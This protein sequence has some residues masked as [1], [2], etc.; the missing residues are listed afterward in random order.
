MKGQGVIGGLVILVVAS[1]FV[2]TIISGLLRPAY[3]LETITNESVA[4]TAG[5]GTLAYYPIS[6][7][8]SVSNTTDMFTAVTDYNITTASTGV[9]AFGGAI[10]TTPV[11]VTYKYEPAGYIASPFGT[12][13]TVAKNLFVIIIVGLLV[14]AV[15]SFGMG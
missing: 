10:E 14:I 8:T 7:I 2:S 15:G 11:D 5:A 12:A 13:R 4:I 1:I 6:S 9:M 3:T